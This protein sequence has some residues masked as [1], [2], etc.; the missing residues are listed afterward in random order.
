MIPPQGIL[1]VDKPA[2]PT[3]HDVVDHLRKTAGTRRVGHAG[4]LDPFASGLLLLLVGTATRLSEYFLGMEKDYEATIRLG[5]E[6]DSHDSEGE[7]LEERVVLVRVAPGAGYSWIPT[8]R[9]I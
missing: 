8:P 9:M 7:V 4:T 5:V 3:S 6:T 2:G 1:L